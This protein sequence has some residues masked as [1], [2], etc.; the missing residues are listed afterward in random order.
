MPTKAPTEA[1]IEKQLKAVRLPPDMSLG[2][3]FENVAAGCVTVVTLNYTLETE[4]PDEPG[5][6]AL[7][8]DRHVLRSALDDAVDWRHLL[9]V[10]AEVGAAELIA[11][12]FHAWFRCEPITLLK[13]V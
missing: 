9:A 8:L 6:V 10:E 13:A 3:K 7:D 4:Q 2:W 11:H 1:Q 12:A 5:R